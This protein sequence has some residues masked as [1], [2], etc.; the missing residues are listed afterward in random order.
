[1]HCMRISITP[2]CRMFKCVLLPAA[3]DTQVRNLPK[4]YTLPTLEQLPSELPPANPSGKR[5]TNRL[6]MLARRDIE[7]G[8]EL[9]IPYV[10][11]DLPREQ[12]RQDLRE[13]Y[14]FWCNCERCERGE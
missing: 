1:M 9:T 4:D 7:V 3:A 6:T 8:Q 5:G 13:A 14:G 2:A 11:F 10:N 12:R